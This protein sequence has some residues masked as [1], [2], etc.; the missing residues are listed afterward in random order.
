MNNQEIVENAPFG[1]THYAEN[2]YFYFI[3][4]SEYLLF[5]IKEGLVYETTN[6]YLPRNPRLLKD[7]KQIVELEGGVNNESK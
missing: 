2:G 1:A 6:K 7:I 3:N 4:P 5:R